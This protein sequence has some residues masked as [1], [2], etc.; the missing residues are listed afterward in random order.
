[1]RVANA[2]LSKI[3]RKLTKFTQGE[4]PKFEICGADIKKKA[5]KLYLSMGA[6][7]QRIHNL[8]LF[9]VS[10]FFIGSFYK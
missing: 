5:I 6:F 10:D 4:K 3:V 7:E 2:R 8:L 1:M 9:S